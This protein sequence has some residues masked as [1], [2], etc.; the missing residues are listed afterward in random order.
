MH[1]G[2][3]EPP[4]PGASGVGVA[5][6]GEVV[7]QRVDPHVHDV[8]GVVGHRHTPFEAG[9]RDRE[10]IESPLD[11]ADHLVAPAVGQH[12][13]GVL[14]V[15]REQP[16]LPRREP[17]E[18]ARLLD[19]FDRRAAGRLAVD[20]LGLGVERFVAH[21]IPAGIGAEVDLVARDEFAPELLHRGLVARLGGA[22]EV[23]VGKREQL[24]ETAERLGNAVDELLRRLAGRGRRLFHLLA[25]LVGTGQEHHLAP[26]EP[27][28]TRQRVAGQ[29]GVRVADMRLVVDV[30]NRRGDVEAFCL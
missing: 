24:A 8:V 3:P 26:V 7:G 4:V 9:A 1:V 18:V 22:D 21:R 25:V 6:A 11:E 16:V 23:V 19:P 27:H 2:G 13:I 28:E 15:E 12:E 10:V 17:E 5:D 29:R 20:Q 30:I 14:V